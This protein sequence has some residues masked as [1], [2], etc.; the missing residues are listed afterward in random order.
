M[1]QPVLL[2]LIDNLVLRVQAAQLGDR[3]YP[4]RVVG[5]DCGTLEAL[6]KDAR[7]ETEAFGVVCGV[8]DLALNLRMSVWDN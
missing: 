7:S 8:E 5:G 2:L 1:L 4:R 6:V 3:S